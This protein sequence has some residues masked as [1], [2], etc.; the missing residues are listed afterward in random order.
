MITNYD[1]WRAALKALREGKPLPSIQENA[2]Q[3]GF[4]RRRFPGKDGPWL[5]AALFLDKVTGEVCCAFNK[6]KGG[7]DYA[8]EHWTWLARN[9][10]TEDVYRG[11]IASGK[12]PDGADGAEAPKSNMPADPFEKLKVEYEDALE[13]AQRILGKQAALADKVSCDTAANLS[14]TL[15]AIMNTA[16][17]LFDAEKKPIREAGLAVDAKYS[18]RKQ[19]AEVIKALKKLVGAYLA[20]EERKAQEEAEKK[21]QAEIKKIEEERAAREAELKKL[22]AEDPALANLHRAELA[23]EPELPI[24]APSQPIKMRAG[25]GVGPKVGLKT[26]YRAEITDYTL[27]LAHFSEYGQVKA[28]IQDLASGVVR[29]TKGAQEIPGVRVVQ[30]REAA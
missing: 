26:V 8:I 19:G 4:Y 24:S 12:W 3:L 21:R 27:A 9:P 15:S 2:P 18:F 28:L 22:E 6:K 1:Y 10:I 7:A 20:A 13:S 16:D 5:P 17:D 29:A 30:N 23:K 11:Y 14:R 25:G